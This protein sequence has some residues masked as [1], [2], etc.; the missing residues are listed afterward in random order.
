MN[1]SLPPNLTTPN[2]TDAASEHLCKWQSLV[3]QLAA[4][5]AEA[6]VRNQALQAQ[7][8]EKDEAIEAYKRRL[9][10]HK[11]EKMPRPEADLRNR[12]DLSKPTPEEIRRRRAEGRKWKEEL[13]TETVLHLLPETDKRCELCGT[14]P[15]HPLPD[16]VSY[17]TELVP[18][19]VVR[20]RHIVSRARCECGSCV[21][22]APPPPRIGE[23]VQY[24]PRLVA[25]LI[26][27]KCLDAVAVERYATQLQR[28][29][30]PVSATTLFDLFHAAARKL[31]W[32]YGLLLQW[33]QM[34]DV[35]HADETRIQ[36]LDNLGPKPRTPEQRAAHAK[37]RRAWMWV[38]I[39]G[40]IVIY[41]YSPSRSGETPV[42][43][44]GA[45]QGTLVVDGY[46]GY[47]QVTTPAGRDRSGCMAHARRGLFEARR[48]VPEMQEGLDLILDLYK[49]EHDAKA[50]GV[51][52]TAAHAALRRERSQPIL[53][54]LHTWL[55][56]QK[57]LQLP[58]SKAG[59]A[60]GY[61]LNQW[62]AL[63]RFAANPKIPIDNNL[64]ERMLRVVARGRAT[65]M[66]VGNDKCGQNLAMLMTLV[67][68]A[69]ACGH[70]PEHYLANVL[71]RI[72]DHPASRAEELL[73]QNWRDPALA[74][75]PPPAAAPGPAATTDEGV[76]PPGEDGARDDQPAA[77]SAETG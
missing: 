35:V 4:S 59:E 32:L 62:R 39:S 65:Y 2:A 56:G 71:L 29:G 17:T 49:V 1:A 25:S 13:P 34:R 51:G 72:D 15:D 11:G 68:T 73:P 52:G 8:Q 7:L 70:N 63:T 57:A 21:I 38:F 27:A 77:P 42:E 74:A 44:L 23:K 64:S 37:T 26:A 28:M 30:A 6:E 22:S 69:M 41:K 61:M 47:N 54:K 46:T 19:R 43:V 3:V 36:A 45:S 24:G 12:G 53:D 20:H 60:V 33:M 76:G 9:F 5:L 55:L 10:G 14:A 16:E 67:H 40:D 58:T 31:E 66:F 18:S 48:N 50:Q 75:K